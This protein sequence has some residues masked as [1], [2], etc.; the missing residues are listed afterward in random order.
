M[1]RVLKSEADCFAYSYVHRH[2]WSNSY[3]L[4]V[5]FDNIQVVTVNSMLVSSKPERKTINR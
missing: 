4:I 1:S 5:V 3:F 2:A